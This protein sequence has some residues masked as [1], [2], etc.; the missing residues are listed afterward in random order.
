[1]RVLFLSLPSLYEEQPAYPLGVG[2]LVGSLRGQQDTQV[3]HLTNMWGARTQIRTRLESFRPQVVALACTT[4]NRV[5]VSRAIQWVRAFDPAIRVVVGGVHASYCADQVLAAYGADVVVVGE[6]EIT[7][8]ELLRS[9]EAGTSLHEVQ[10]IVFRDAN[11]GVICT[12]SRPPIA[13]L[14]DLPLPDYEYGAA[15]M[16]ALGMGFLITTRG[17][18]VRCEFCS[19]SSYWGQKVRMYSAERVVD[20]MQLLQTRFG[21]SRIF[22]YDDTFNVGIGRVNEIC[23]AIQARRVKIEWGC[24]CRVTPVSAEMIANMVAAGCRHICWGIESGSPRMLASIHKHITVEQIRQAF[25]LCRPY[26]DRLS[27]GAFVMVGNPGENAES[28]RETTE[29]LRTLPLTDP[30]STSILYVLPGTTLFE[31]LKQAGQIRDADWLRYNTVPAYTLEHSYWTLLRW[32]KQIN[33]SI[34]RMPYD[35]AQHFWR[36]QPLPDTASTPDGGAVVRLRHVWQQVRRIS[37]GMSKLLP[38]GRIRF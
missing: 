19:T 9:V 26:Q 25:E 35:V 29:L 12:P 6:G 28:I 22:F 4:F 8:S 37:V 38:R 10:G 23:A 13:R 32:A 17:C 3:L 27:T 5:S 20:E 21:L 24:Q 18:P 16:R 7:L 31:R 11:G 15:S 33:K 34:H 1:M 36:R 2:Y 30:I 14:D